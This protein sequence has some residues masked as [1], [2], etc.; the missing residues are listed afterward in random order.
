[1]GEQCLYNNKEKNEKNCTIP[2]GKQRYNTFLP[3]QLEYDSTVVYEEACVKIDVFSKTKAKKG[4]CFSITFPKDGSL[5]YAISMLPDSFSFA[6]CEIDPERAKGSLLERFAGALNQTPENIRSYALIS[7]MSEPK[8]A[9]G[10]QSILKPVFLRYFSDYGA[11][12]EYEFSDIF[13]TSEFHRLEPPDPSLPFLKYV[14]IGND[15]AEI[16]SRHIKEYPY[17]PAPSLS[18]FYGPLSATR[19]M[20]ANIH[21]PYTYGFFDQKIIPRYDKIDPQI[22]KK[23]CNLRSRIATCLK[24]DPLNIEEILEAEQSIYDIMEKAVHIGGFEFLFNMEDIIIKA[25]ENGK[26]EK[27]TEG[28][29]AVFD[30]AWRT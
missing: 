17:S 14:R 15:Q 23:T 8:T 4:S 12:T 19:R 11:M 29:F 21:G 6:V 9:D 22:L 20:V 5:S 24:I 18:S 13:C 27:L 26:M 28:F 10:I 30:A 7:M 2:K 3:P 1:M 16:L 25:A